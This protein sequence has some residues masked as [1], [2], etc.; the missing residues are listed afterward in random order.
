[1]KCDEVAEYVSALYDGESVPP[2][3]AEHIARCAQCRE[4]LKEYAQMGA[5]MRSYGGLLIAKPLVAPTWLTIGQNRSKWWK[6]GLETMRIPRI[7]L[8]SL[9]FLLIVLGSRLAVVE[10]RAHEDGSVLMLRLTPAQGDAVSCDVS[11]SD[12]QLNKC[13]GL[14][15]INKTNLLYAVKALRKDGSRVLLSIRTKASPLGPGAFDQ[16]TENSMPEMQVWFTP[17]QIL[18]LPNTGMLNLTLTGQWADHIPVRI[19]TN[20]LLDP[21]PNEIR[22]TSPLLLKNNKV[23]GDMA[24]ASADADQPGDGV[25]FYLPGEGR[26]LLS[27]TQF[28]GAVTA[29][30][31]LNRI[32]F[33]S[34]GQDYVIVTGMPVSRSAKVWV[35]HDAASMPAHDSVQ[36]AFIGA[37]PIGKIL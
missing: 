32:S 11:T 30:V 24:N 26:F 5:T 35:L 18:S 9:V 27:L 22:L 28:A 20:Q 3:M 17:G 10:V 12:M 2:K 23:A 14:A 21:G 4:L 34:E 6:K 19:G 15:Q 29:N 33:K 13:G 8:G 31:Q 1:M 25:V 36:R 7:A 16:D 37:G